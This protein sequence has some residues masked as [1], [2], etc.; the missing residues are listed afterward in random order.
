MKLCCFF[1]FSIAIADSFLNV[2]LLFD[3]TVL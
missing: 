2:N 3:E 1:Q